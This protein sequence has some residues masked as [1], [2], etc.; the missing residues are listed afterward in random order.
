MEDNINTNFN[1]VEIKSNIFENLSRVVFLIFIFLLPIWIL[2]TTIFPLEMNKAYLSFFAVAIITVLWLIGFIQSGELKVPK[3]AILLFLL[4]ITVVWF[5]AALFSQNRP[6]SFVGEGY[7]LDSFGII[8]LFTF[9]AVLIS[10]LFQEEKWS[11]QIFY[12]F[13][14]SAF[15]LFV[16]QFFRSL[17]NLTILP[18]NVFPVKTSNLLGSWSELGIFFGLVGLESLVF[19]QFFKKKKAFFG[20]ILGLSILVLIGVNFKAAWALLAG[21]SMLILIYIFSVSKERRII[22]GLPLIIFIIAV[23][24]I[25]LRPLVGDLLVSADLNYLEVRPSWSATFEIVKN[26]LR[27]NPILG[28]GPG[29]F[30]YNWLSFKPRSI[31]LTPFWNAR[32]N[33]GIGL[34]PSLAASAG[35]LG[36]LAWL[37]FFIFFLIQILKIINI[38]NGKENNI[39][40]SLVLVSFFGAAYL[41]I[42][43]VIYVS[44]FALFA[45]AFIFTGLTVAQIARIGKIRVW[46]V[47][48]MAGPKIRFIA[49]LFILVIIIAAIGTFYV[50][51]KKY[52]ASYYFAKG[53]A[54]FNSEGN[55]EKTENYFLKSANLDPQDRYFRVLGELGLLKLNKILNNIEL[56]ADELRNQFQN[57]LSST[58]QSG[59]SAVNINKLDPLNWANL[60]KIYESVIPLKIEGT[61]DLALKNYDEAL[62]RDPTNP[63]YFIAKARILVQTNKLDD[64]KNFLKEAIN[65]KSDYATPHFILSQ[66]EAAGG[67]LKEA[68]AR[69]R[70]AQFLAQNDIGILF[71]LGLLYYQ[72][73]EY[74]NAKQV[75]QKTVFINQNYSNARYFL[76]LIYD[77]EGDKDKAI[78]EFEKIETLNPDNQEVKKI[79]ANLKAGKPALENIAPPAP[80]PE[81]RES[82]PIEPKK[83][84]GQE[85]K[86]EE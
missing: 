61:S 58:I 40:Q 47:N 69:T 6:L 10:F 73:Q 5:L 18:F 70:D 27:N 1:K 83:Q 42:F 50:F 60:A 16:F 59:Q 86:T 14:G 34:I 43:N 41:W 19:L 17:F 11:L 52:A 26:S 56:P 12:A 48:F 76:G 84:R 13:F 49:S 54:V 25:F 80:Q 79:L 29:T 64:A 67:N 85:L 15:V 51:S 44:T 66:I 74:D 71:Q 30:V 77:R 3:S 72:N 78:A 31:N 81:K 82:P 33:Y 75:F 55:A 39:S 57:G 65:L 21:F 68:I 24:F 7:N 63:D 28:T 53:I 32:F 8:A 23:L 45:L 37:C 46:N 20:I 9:L 22:T 2:P 62:K 36:I 38:K 35:I 4:A